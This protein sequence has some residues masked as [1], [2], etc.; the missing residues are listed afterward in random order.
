VSVVRTFDWIGFCIGN[1]T[2]IPEIIQITL[3]RRSVRP[4]VRPSVSIRWQSVTR[5]FPVET[6]S[7]SPCSLRSWPERARNFLTMLPQRA[8][9]IIYS[10]RLRSSSSK[11]APV[12]DWPGFAARRCVD[13]R[14][15]GTGKGWFSCRRDVLGIAGLNIFG[16]SCRRFSRMAGR[17]GAPHMAVGEY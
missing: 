10:R 8:E 17:R 9:G 13:W 3:V 15:R 5:E 7:T 6:P 1:S 16:L 2:R 11:G 4:S 14:V 12:M